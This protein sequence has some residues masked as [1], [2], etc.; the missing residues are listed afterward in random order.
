MLTGKELGEAIADA[1]EKKG[2]SKA[3]VAR[4]FG[5]KPPSVQDWIKFGRISKRHLDGIF[6]YFSDVAG[7]E[8]WGL[9]EQKKS[10]TPLQLMQYP[11]IEH[12]QTHQVAEAIAEF[13]P[14]VGSYRATPVIGTAQLGAE[15]YWD[16]IEYPVGHGDGYVDAP[17]RDPNAYALRVKGDSMAPAIR[18]GWLVIVEPNSPV[19]PG[20]LVLICTANGQC[21][22]KE[23]LYE[24][25]GE[26]SLGSINQ[27]SKPMTFNQ[28]DITRFHSIGFIVPPSKWRLT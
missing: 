7:P 17:T 9:T 18:N 16:A 12:E 20:E 11:N 25:G 21:M 5:V 13:G 4:H 2:V 14:D 23:F 27:D 24:R 3:E 15:G 22:V 8:H 28:A 10:P 1:I 26:I 19:V 6:E